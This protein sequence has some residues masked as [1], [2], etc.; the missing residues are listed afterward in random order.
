MIE[1]EDLVKE[2]DGF[3]ALNG[4]SFK[5]NE[6]E[7]FA[8]LGPNGAGK[9]T[10]V[11]I[12]TTLLKP[13][14]GRAYVAGYDVVRNAKD[15]R[16]KI[17]VVFQDPSLDRD[18]TAYENLLIHAGVYG[19]EKP[20]IKWALEFVGLWEF[21]N[22]V[23]RFFS[24]GM[25]R[26]LEI[27]RALL[28]EPEVL[29]LD[30]P[31]LGLDPQTRAKIWELIDSLDVTV[32]LTTH[33]MDEAERLADRVAI[34]DR[35]RIIAIGSVE[36][37]KRM[38]GGDLIFLRV[39]GKFEGIEHVVL[40]DGRIMIEVKNATEFIPELFELAKAKG[41]RIVEIEY[42][43]PTL[44]DVFLQLTGREIRNGEDD[45]LKF[46]IARRFRR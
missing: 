30:E 20:D 35:G 19:I 44:N 9:T 4:I 24:G 27:A 15:V 11:N 16:R 31:T 25:Q 28:H 36:E 40:P 18:L 10:T 14:S 5:V 43:R 38:V 8:F 32:F 1:V 21:R 33:Y 3:R 29:F 7:V 23:V 26:R 39:E 46:A 22:K 45:S 42:R 17:G 34:I 12:L 2:F 37:L 41:F 6:G 13:T